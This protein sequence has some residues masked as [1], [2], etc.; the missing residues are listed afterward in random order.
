MIAARLA[1]GAISLGKAQV[2]Q[3]AGEKP[4]QLKLNREKKHPQPSYDTKG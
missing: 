1:N 2:A 3:K 4:K